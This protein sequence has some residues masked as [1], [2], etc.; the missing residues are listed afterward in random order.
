MKINSTTGKIEEILRSNFSCT[1][2]DL[3]IGGINN[4]YFY[5]GCY[6]SLAPFSGHGM[7]MLSDLQSLVHITS[8][9]Y[10]D[11]FKIGEIGYGNN[12]RLLLCD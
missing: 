3:K 7:G 8:I 9:K 11:F 2:V 4:E 1:S 10:Y 5:Y 6:S 12:T